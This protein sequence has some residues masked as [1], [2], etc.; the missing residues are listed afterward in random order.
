MLDQKKNC[1]FDLADLREMR[2]EHH[3]P[4]LGA[5]HNEEKLT[6]RHEDTKG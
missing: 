3:E 6:R 5:R 4:C 1:E 2:F